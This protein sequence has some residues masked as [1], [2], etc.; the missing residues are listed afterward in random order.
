MNN[1]SDKDASKHR[2]YLKNRGYSDHDLGIGFIRIQEKLKQHLLSNNFNQDEMDNVF[3]NDAIKAMGTS[4]QLTIPFR[5][6]RENIV[7]FVF[8]DIQL[9]EGNKYLYMTDF[10]KSHYL[11]NLKN[12]RKNKKS[13]VIVEGLP[14]AITSHIHRMD[15]V[16]ALGGNSISD[17]Q[18]K[19]I[20]KSGAESITLC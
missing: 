9:K 13:L 15:N 2:E 10:K 14:D 12:N 18:I 6:N 5:D 20:K 19:L 11:F 4:H 1:E 7:S 17:E 16:A 3:F 8:R